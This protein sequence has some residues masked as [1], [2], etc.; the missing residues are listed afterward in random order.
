M[1]EFIGASAVIVDGPAG[2]LIDR[3]SLICSIAARAEEMRLSG[4]GLEDRIVVAPKS[5]A[6]CL[7]DLFAAWQSGITVVMVSP[8]LTPAERDIVAATTKARAWVGEEGPTNVVCLGT[9]PLIEAQNEPPMGPGR[10]PFDAPALILMTSG[11]TSAPKGVV[12]SLR[13]LAARVALNRAYI[14]DADLAHTLNL[15]P[16]HFGHGLIGNTL[17]PLSAGSRLALWPEPGVAGLSRLG[18]VIDDWGITFLSS[19]PAVWRV[20]LRLSKPPVCGTLR[21]IHIGSAPL[22][23]D[24]WEQVAAW[25][26]IRRIVNMYGITETANWIG[27]HNLE[28]GA[29]EDGLVGR[30]WG[31]TYAILDS[32]GV[33]QRSGRGPVLV[34]T[35][36]RMLGYFER[37]DLNRTAFAGPWFVTGDSGEID[38]SGILRLSGRRQNEINRGGLK[39]SAE[40]IDLLLERHPNVLEACAFPLEDPVAG[41]IVAAAVVVGPD[42]ALSE[43]ELIAWCTDRIRSEAVPSRIFL[44]NALPRNDRG[45]LNRDVVKRAALGGEGS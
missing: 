35:P 40:E 29:A 32:G 34:S 38:A 12:H 45:K 11:T 13:S 31:G 15:L 4:L 7:V 9:A 24:L 16:L 36:S 10:L 20:A 3:A 39:V 42:H 43:P 5:A 44:L 8:G 1:L 22:A 6:A 19:V 37:N 14:E 28:D 33:L 17:T 26:G 41:E 18:A 2:R 21:R 23:A 30:P 25:A 27:G